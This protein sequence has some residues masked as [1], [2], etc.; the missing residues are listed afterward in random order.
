MD[1]GAQG[2][3]AQQTQVLVQQPP[4]QQQYAP[5]VQPDESTLY[6]LACIF[7]NCCGLSVI[8]LTM[9]CVAQGL[10]ESGQATQAAAANIWE[11]AR[12]FRLAGLICGAVTF[13]IFIIYYAVVGAQIYSNIQSNNSN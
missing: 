9:H 10:Y 2:Q 11:K 13:V 1:G 7:C 8:A 5:V 3:Y 6:W 12:Q 4:R